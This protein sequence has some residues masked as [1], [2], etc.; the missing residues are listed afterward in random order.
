MY[1]YGGFRV[2]DVGRLW[3]SGVG[4]TVVYLI[5]GGAWFMLSEQWSFTDTVYFVVSG[6]LLARKGSLA[7]AL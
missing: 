4:L 6:V 3:W 7:Y 5:G 2:Q 1:T